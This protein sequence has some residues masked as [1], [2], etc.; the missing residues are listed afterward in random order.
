MWEER[1]RHVEGELEKQ[2]EGHLTHLEEWEQ[3]TEG[4][5]KEEIPMTGLHPIC[6]VLSLSSSSWH[7]ILHRE[8]EYVD[9]FNVSL[10]EL[11]H[12]FPTPGTSV[13]VI[14]G[15]TVSGESLEKTC[16]LILTE[17]SGSC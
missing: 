15:A 1:D 8:I 11:S 2:L 7:G 5:L 9:Q 10:V 4:K 16:A 13:L 6:L 3:E 12:S 17:S 14:L